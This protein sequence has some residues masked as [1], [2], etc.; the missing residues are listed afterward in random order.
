MISTVVRRSLLIL[1]SLGVWLSAS[2]RAATGQN[3]AIP[4]REIALE[5]REK[6]VADEM[7][8]PHLL[9]IETDDGIVTLSGTV[10]HLL[11]KERAVEIA[12][13]MK[14]VRGV[15]VKLDVRPVIQTDEQIREDAETALSGDPAAEAYNIEIDVSDGILTLNGTVESH[16]EKRIAE[17]VVKGVKGVKFVK[18]D[19]V[20]HYPEQRSDQ[21]IRRE[22]E[23][24]LELNPTVEESL[25]TVTVENGT[26]NLTGTIGAVA[27]RKQVVRAAWA[28]GASAVDAT[29]LMLEWWTREDTT[30]AQRPL[31]RT[32]AEIKEAVKD[33]LTYDPRV[34]SFDIAV[35]VENGKVRLSGSVDNYKAKLAAAEAARKV[36]GVWRVKNF[37]TVRPDDLRTD[38]EIE[39]EVK[40]ALLR[41][42]LVNR[43]NLHVRVMNNKVYLR[44]LVNSFAEHEQAE[45]VAS[46]V[47]GVVDVQNSIRID[48]EL[49]WQSDAE[50]QENIEDEYFW[51]LYVDGD[52]VHVT[53]ERGTAILTGSVADWQEHNAAVENAFDGGATSVISHLNLESYPLINDAPRYYEN[54]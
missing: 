40:S 52:D 26:V 5:L 3:P 43:Y 21:E 54:Q 50:I 14:G 37:I 7:I 25:I 29:G 12:E 42:P 15:N 2:P 10:D 9:D 18:N 8:S 45:D 51:S 33:V 20:V 48:T 23:R 30:S 13:E 6:L 34:Y 27:E 16:A 28:S 1:L 31:I 41:D 11:A 4:D 24:R 36:F 22:V 38:A 17:D 46:R 47:Q 39:Q 35:E 32:D 44:G 53:V 49:T 19:L